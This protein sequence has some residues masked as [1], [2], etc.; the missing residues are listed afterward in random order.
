MVGDIIELPSGFYLTTRRKKIRAAFR[1]IT[2]R[3]KR[4]VYRHFMARKRGIRKYNQI[5]PKIFK[6]LP[7]Q[8]RLINKYI[9]FDPGLNAFAVMYPLYNL[10]KD[11]QHRLTKSSVLTLQN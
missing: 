4:T 6:R 5:I 9:A 3:A 11:V 8:V 2:N 1:I 10:T 7:T